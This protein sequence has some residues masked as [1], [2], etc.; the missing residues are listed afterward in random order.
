M[1]DSR[2]GT[3]WRARRLGSRV[4]G[5]R[6][7]RAGRHP[8]DA[9]GARD[10]R[11]QDGR[12]RGAGLQQ[13]V[14]RVTSSITRSG[15]SRKRCGGSG[16]S[17]CGPPTR[18]A[19]RPARRW[20]SIASGSRRRS[21]GS[22]R[23]TRASRSPRRG[24]AHPDWSGRPAHHRHRAIDVRLAVGRHR[25]AGRREHLYFYDAISPIVLAETIDMSKVFRASRWGRSLGVRPGSDPGQT[26]VRPLRGPSL[27]R[28]RWGRVTI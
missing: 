22:S 7:R 20:P 26:R 8:R 28:G 15:S 14:S 12:P 21:R 9:A 6:G 19:C 17:S 10:G 4:A 1:R 3:S 16:R 24:P 2:A 11:A 13:L 25:R 23:R 5:G 18:R 27:R